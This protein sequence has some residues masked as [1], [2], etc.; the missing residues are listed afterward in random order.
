MRYMVTGC[1]ASSF[2]LLSNC[3]LAGIN[4]GVDFGSGQ[5]S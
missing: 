2:F 5:L 1:R 3:K 4:E